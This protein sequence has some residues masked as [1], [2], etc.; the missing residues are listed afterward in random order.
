MQQAI[1][2]ASKYNDFTGTISQVIVGENGDAFLSPNLLFC[3]REIKT[4]LPGASVTLY[5]NFLSST[6]ELWETIMRECLVN[7]VICNIDSMESSQYGKA[8]NADF[9]VM[10]NSF[11][12]FLDLRKALNKDILLEVNVLDPIVYLNTA[13]TV[14]NQKHKKKFYEY[15]K[16]EDMSVLTT[17]YLKMLLYEGDKIK[18]VLPCLWAERDKMKGLKNESTHCPHINKVI[19]EAFIAPDGTWYGCCLD[20]KYEIRLGNIVEQSFFDI[21]EGELRNEFINNLIEGRFELIGS[22]CNT[23]DCCQCYK[24]GGEQNE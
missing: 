11:L 24:L 4:C 17:N 18:N 10:Y 7:K 9:F 19:T 16:G 20:H 1:R 13:E 15:T 23:V 12:N 5:T 6:P 14:F 21:A 2:Q 22:P 8:K 3:L